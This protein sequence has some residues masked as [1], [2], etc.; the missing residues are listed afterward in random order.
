MNEYYRIPAYPDHL[1]GTSVLTR[2]LDGLGFRFYW[3]TEGLRAEDYDFRPAKDTMSIGELVKHVWSL[4]NWV[5]ST[6]L[7]TP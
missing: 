5:S 4:V 7:S 6:A 3:A 2:M 1:S